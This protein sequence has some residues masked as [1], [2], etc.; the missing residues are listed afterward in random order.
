MDLTALVFTTIAVSSSG[1]LSPGPLTVATLAIGSRYGWKGGGYIALGH[2]MFEVPYIL[3]LYFF[4]SYIRDLL[5]GFVG[6]IVTIVGAGTVVFFAVMLL[7]D[8]FKKLRAVGYHVSIDGNT[9]SK[10][11]KFSNSPVLVGIVF[12]GLNIWF[13][14]W[15]LSIGF[16]LL[17]YISDMGLTAIG[18]MYLSHVW[19]DFAWLILVAETSKRGTQLVGARGYYLLMVF[20]GALLLVFGLNIVLKRFAQLSL[21]P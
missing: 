7:K 5:E 16:G 19:I 12:T 10:W 15:W 20:L 11:I 6:D 9:D 21:L 8:S 1:A 3:T 4:I 17:M 14:L 2:T 13:L 18:I